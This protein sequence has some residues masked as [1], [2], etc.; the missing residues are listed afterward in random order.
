[1]LRLEAIRMTSLPKVA[2]DML[3]AVRV[4]GDCCWEVVLAQTGQ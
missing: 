3:L 2:N 4:Y 1:M